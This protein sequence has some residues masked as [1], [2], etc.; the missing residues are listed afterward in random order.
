M[1][2]EPTLT[3]LRKQIEDL[4]KEKKALKTLGVILK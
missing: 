1:A 4:K 3:E 2:T